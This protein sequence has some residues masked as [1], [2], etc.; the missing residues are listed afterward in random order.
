MVGLSRWAG[1]FESVTP[2]SADVEGLH[3]FRSFP[4]TFGKEEVRDF[5][6]K[7]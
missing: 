1:S 3:Y 5:V 6:E 4:L 2:V 7:P